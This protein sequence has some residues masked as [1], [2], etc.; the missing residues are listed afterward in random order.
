MAI[1]FFIIK[2][3]SIILNTVRKKQKGIEREIRYFI[4][5]IVY[6]FYKMNTFAL[7]ISVH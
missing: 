1:K 5:Y 2:K 4:K 7:L 3:E 6:L